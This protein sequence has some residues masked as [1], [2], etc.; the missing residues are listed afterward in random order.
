ASKTVAVPVERLFDAF[1]DARLRKKWLAEGR[2]SLRTSQPNR[3][4]RFDWEGGPTRVNVEFSDKGP[5]KSTVAVAHERL[6][7]AH[8][9]ETTKASW[10]ARLA[11]LKS[12]LES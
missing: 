12:F 4:A 7:S 9:A 2:M 5:S 6:G 11:E 1:V 3:S 10:K 8:Q